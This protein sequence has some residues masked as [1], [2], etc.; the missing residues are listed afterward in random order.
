MPQVIAISNTIP[1]TIP[2]GDILIYIGDPVNFSKFKEELSF[3][4]SKF[5]FIVVVPGDKMIRNYGQVCRGLKDI[6]VHLLVDKLIEL[7]GLKI[8]GSK[9]KDDYSRIPKG[10]DILI[11]N[12]CPYGILDNNCGSIKLINRIR[13]IIP[14]Y[15]VFGQ[16]LGTKGMYSWKTATT[17]FTRFFNT[18]GIVTKFWID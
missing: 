15:H 2:D 4:A 11:T 9:K 18:A 1:D 8:Y 13:K 12:E 6:G 7:D 16:V 3:K 17:R 14:R 5:E 10:V